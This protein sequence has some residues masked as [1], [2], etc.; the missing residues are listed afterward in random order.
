L[1]KKLPSFIRDL[2]T[3]KG[4]LN[5]SR[6]LLRISLVI[7]FSFV[8]AIINSVLNPFFH[9]HSIDYYMKFHLIYIPILFYLIVWNLIF[10]A[11]IIKR[12]RDRGNSL[13]YLLCLY[14]FTILRCI[15]GIFGTLIFDFVF[16]GTIY[17]FAMNR[18]SLKLKS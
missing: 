15:P 9:Y 6:Y 1:F 2:F 8:I 10:S 7:M 13:W 3:F 5:R 16:Y 4:K 12:L 17:L 18:K 14:C 11:T